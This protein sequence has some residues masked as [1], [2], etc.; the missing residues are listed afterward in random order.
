MKKF[1]KRQ[2]KMFGLAIAVFLCIAMIFCGLMLASG[3]QSKTIWAETETIQQEDGKIDQNL[4]TA[5]KDYY[6]QNKPAGAQDVTTSLSTDLFADASF[7]GKVLNLENKS[8]FSIYNLN[9]FDLSKFAGINLSNNKLDLLSDGLQNAK[10]ENIDLSYNKLKE[11]K[12]SAINCQNLQTLNI[13]H[14]LIEVCDLYNAVSDHGVSV[15]ARFN[16]I[17][18]FTLPKNTTTQVKISHNLIDVSLLSD[19]NKETNTNID[20]GFQGVVDA[21]ELVTGQFPKLQYF[22]IDGV[23]TVKV[24]KGDAEQIDYSTKLAE[25]LSGT[26]KPQA[27]S[28][29]ST[30]D[31]SNQRYEILEFGYYKVTFFDSDDQKTSDETKDIY[32]RVAPIKPVVKMVQDGKVLESVKAFV[33]SPCKLT[34]EETAGVITVYR[35]LPAGDY[36]VGNTIEIAT[37]GMNYFE[38]YQI[39]EGCLSQAQKITINYQKSATMGWIYVVIAVAVFTV[40]FYVAY[41]NIPRIS[42]I[43]QKNKKGKKNL[44]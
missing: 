38:V 18:N 9:L 24:F 32:F 5:L 41:I 15:D 12:S 10:F 1:E 23:D 44:D 11:F 26:Y 37:E 7:E 31:L 42:A 8:I 17:S 22:G 3:K 16:K 40:I 28:V 25:I 19:Y 39:C 43:G 35:R 27:Y 14:N 29:I 21:S 13:S 34:I 36:V 2:T 6:N 33:A 30:L 4:W 20:F